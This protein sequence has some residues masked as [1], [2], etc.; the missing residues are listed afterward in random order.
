MPDG[1]GVPCGGPGLEVTTM[2]VRGPGRTHRGLVSTATAGIAAVGIV[3]FGTP[4]AEAAPT[5]PASC[6]VRCVQLAVAHPVLTG[7]TDA[8]ATIA[9]ALR[10]ARPG[11]TVQLP[12]G[13]F[14]VS[15]PIEVPDGVS[16]A[17]SGIDRTTVLLDRRT[18]QR[19]SFG[20]LLSPAPGASRGSTV[21]D[22]T[23]NG[24][25]VAVDRLGAA[26]RPADNQGGGVKLGNGWQVRNV[27]LSN[28]NYF[29]VWA[30]DVAGVTV[31]NCLFEERGGGLS[32]GNDN[33]GGGMVRG[34]VIRN[35]VF[36]PSARGNSVDIVRG[37]N[38]R[39][40][41]NLMIGTA[42]APHNVYLE[43]VTDS[44][45]A[46]NELVRSSISVQS[47]AGYRSQPD[48]VNPSRVTI[49]GN[50]ITAPAAQGVSLRY[51]SPAGLRGI[52]GG[53]R[54]TG[55]S[56]TDSGVAG[57]VVMAARAGLVGA[58]DVISGNTVTD[59][60]SRGGDTWNTGYGIAKAAGIVVGVGHGSDVT[61]N[62]VVDT[63][64]PARLS[65]G[66]QFGL[67]GERAIPVDLGDTQANRVSGVP[68]ALVFLAPGT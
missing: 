68:Q 63:R 46:R 8:H 67:P 4:A 36:G 13:T 66:M 25:R 53:N 45:V 32:G 47:N 29:K 6:G 65:Y 60:F 54:I 10:S 26:V 18:W 19:F 52:A 23:L 55:N 34:A 17:G 40:E 57:I 61:A 14:R 42:T 15:R 21:H 62:T 50:R 30:K 1:E 33:V 48:I 38:L 56:V 28:L 41:A 22:L 5:N 44:S 16:L 58:P 2:A 24:N 39:I 27:R 12:P 59:A 37:K 7:T 9:A 31:E 43:G 35:N 20:F 49:Y 51:D 3:G 64:S 11:W